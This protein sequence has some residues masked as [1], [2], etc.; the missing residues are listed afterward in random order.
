MTRGLA[1]GHGR[2]YHRQ[3]RTPRGIVLLAPLLLASCGFEL[4]PTG[5]EC[6]R[7]PADGRELREGEDPLASDGPLGGIDVAAM[8]AA[9]VGELAEQAGVGVTYRYSYDVGEQPD[10]GSQGY[11]ECWCTPPDGQVSDVV[12]DSIGRVVVMV[13]SGE[14]RAAVRPQPQLG[15]GCEANAS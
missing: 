4:N 9:E 12:Y 8:N 7:T 13:D 6:Q 14:H 1:E 5:L 3:V 10:T 11:A 2:L 15:W